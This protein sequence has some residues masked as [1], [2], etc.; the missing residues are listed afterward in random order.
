[1][2]LAQAIKEDSSLVFGL[3]DDLSLLADSIPQT[4]P[5]DAGPFFNGD[6]QIQAMG[7]PPQIVEE[8]QTGGEVHDPVIEEEE[9][10]GDLQTHNEPEPTAWRHLAAAQQ[11]SMA[12]RP[13]VATRWELFSGPGTFGRLTPSGFGRSMASGAPPG[14]G[15]V[16]E[17]PR[18]ADAPDGHRSPEDPS[19][20]PSA[21]QAD[22]RASAN[23]DGQLDPESAAG[24]ADAPA[25]AEISSGTTA[26]IVRR[27]DHGL[28]NV[29]LLLMMVFVLR[30]A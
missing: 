30:I 27:S 2:I 29:V 22:T 16:G 18:D 12:A 24:D 17:L 10:E 25:A 8:E 28:A 20:D 4:D 11:R 15:D 5:P 14:S 23:P 21:S 9:E 26:G 13:L 7:H 6:E 19:P 3:D 1:V